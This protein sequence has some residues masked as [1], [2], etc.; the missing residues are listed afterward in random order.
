MAIIDKKGFIRGRIGNMVYRKVGDTNIIQSRPGEVRQTAAT[1]ESALEFGLASSTAKVLRQM[2]TGLS[3]YADGSMI[4]RLNNTVLNAIRSGT[5][6]TRGQRDLHHADLSTLIGFQFNRNSPLDETLLISPDIVINNNGLVKITIP[7]FESN[8]L[9][10]LPA[11]NGCFLRFTVISVDFKQ[12]YH[13][14]LGHHEIDVS[15]GKNMEQMEWTTPERAEKGSII[16]VALSVVFYAP[17]GIRR[18]G[19]VLNDKSFFPAAIIAAFHS[20]YTANGKEN[21]ETDSYRFPL[22]G[23]QGEDMLRELKRL[24]LKESKKK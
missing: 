20:P 24:Q 3:H 5:E 4:N 14:L 10:W 19:I 15:K 9:C 22:A 1:K 16:L 12:Q 8:E 21:K 13:Q 6:E 11:A 17:D 2:F 18:D 7:A 23:Y